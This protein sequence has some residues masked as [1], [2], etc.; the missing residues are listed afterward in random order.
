M[1]TP[2]IQGALSDLRSA[3]EKLE[4]GRSL[5]RESETALG[6]SVK[7]IANVCRPHC[8]KVAEKYNETAYLR[9]VTDKIRLHFDPKNNLIFMK[10]RLVDSRGDEP[11]EMIDNNDTRLIY[12]TIRKALN[13]KFHGAG[14]PFRLGGVC[15]PDFY[16]VK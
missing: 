14:I 10:V 11:D 12:I 2:D 16:L 13:R 3:G 7:V 5:I 4:G 6:G 8:I 1:P 9:I 15:V